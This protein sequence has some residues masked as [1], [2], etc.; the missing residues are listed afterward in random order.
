MLSRNQIQSMNGVM[1]ASLIRL[2]SLFCKS[3]VPHD[4]LPFFEEIE[5]ISPGDYFF[6]FHDICCFL[7]SIP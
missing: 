4:L 5:G 3:I 2:I 1:P 7:I 6:V